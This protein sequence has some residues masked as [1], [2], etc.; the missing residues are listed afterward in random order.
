MTKRSLD[1]I[2]E[3]LLEQFNKFNRRGDQPGPEMA[4]GSYGLGSV[5]RS[6]SVWSR[7]GKPIERPPGSNPPAAEPA[8]SVPNVWRRGETTPRPDNPPIGGL[9][10]KTPKKKLDEPVDLAKEFEKRSNAAPKKAQPK[11]P[12][13][14]SANKKDRMGRTEPTT[15]QNKEPELRADT[16]TDRIFEPSNDSSAPTWGGRI[17][18]FAGTAAVGGGSLYLLDKYKDEQNK[19]EKEKAYKEIYGPDA[20]MPAPREKPAAREPADP[21]NPDYENL[22]EATTTQ[23]RLLEKYKNFLHEDSA[24]YEDRQDPRQVIEKYLGKRMSNSEYSAFLR[25]VGAES[26]S[27]PLERAHIASVILNRAKAAQGDVIGV[28]NTPS[29]FQAITGPKGNQ[30]TVFKPYYNGARNIIPGIDQ[31]IAG[32]LELV[33]PGL[34]HFSAADPA[35]YKDVG[36][37]KKYRSVMKMYS[38]D[39]SRSR[40]YSSVFGNLGPVPYNP[41][42][43]TMVRQEK[44]LGD[45]F[46]DPYADLVTPTKLA[47][48]NPSGGSAKPT[49]TN[50]EKDK[51][52]KDKEL[53]DRLARDLAVSKQLDRPS[54]VSATPTPAENKPGYYTIGDSHGQGIAVYG[55]GKN[56]PTWVNKSKVGASVVDKDQFATHMANIEKIPAGS[57]VTIS[58]GA[59]DISRSNHQAIVDNL[60]KLIAASKARGH[61]VV[62]V[63]PTESPDP[64]KQEQREALRQT[65][66]K[67]VKDVPIVDLGMASE[68]DKQKVHLDSKGYNRIA[69]NISDMFV[70]GTSNAELPANDKKSKNASAKP[71]ATNDTETKTHPVGTIVQPDYSKYKVGD[72]G[73]L[74]KIGTNQ[75]RS[76]STG[77]IVSDAP[78][79]ENLPSLPK[80]ETFLDKVQRSL[81][82][83]L[84][85]KGEL[86]SQVFGDKKKS[87]A[88][89][90]KTAEPAVVPAATDK[91]PSKDSESS[92]DIER[93]KALDKIIRGVAGDLSGATAADKRDE[94]YRQQL[95]KAKQEKAKQDQEKQKKANDNK[96]VVTKQKKSKNKKVATSTEREPDSLTI[97]ADP[98]PADPP[99]G[100]SAKSSPSEEPNAVVKVTTP[101]PEKIDVKDLATDQAGLAAANDTKIDQNAELVAQKQAEEARRK[102]EADRKAAEAR[103]Q[104]EADR[105]AA[106]ERAQQ[107]LE[108]NRQAAIERAKKAAPTPVQQTAAPDT[109]MGLKNIW[110]KGIEAFTGKQRVNLRDP[111]ITLPES[112]NTELEEILRLAGKK[113]K[114]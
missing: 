29:Q 28:L 92:T 91:Q 25:A 89:A 98:M 41:N 9:V 3:S 100:G 110:D 6:P 40:V 67:G 97:V 81:P 61:K 113:T 13:E 45:K 42:D 56:G 38:T 17:G 46:R 64:A 101:R 65:I 48:A 88:P 107:E 109:G 59:N 69:N 5:T 26:G 32:T 11:E 83:A 102:Q 82:P 57:V 80:P 103:A 8:P 99:K 43:N 74:E 71:S 111:R 2:K 84:G 105:L 1:Q 62:Y 47:Q 7:G 93:G 106:Q 73:P 104:A 77:Q 90:T 108:A 10:G 50:K 44:K 54:G 52:L 21:D 16:R 68:K 76:T 60:N 37:M 23:L 112:I 18:G 33:K 63:L 22:K 49:K 4:G 34:T 58:G 96:V 72:L 94:Y 19:A 27:Q 12:E 24:V 36:G 35:A 15:T 55:K 53:K 78:E 114:E 79:L 31:E 30:G 85:G 75:W 70:P 51:E 20:E 66:L 95:E 14:F 86:V 87:A 39:P